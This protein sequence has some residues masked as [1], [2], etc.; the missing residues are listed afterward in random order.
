LKILVI[1]AR[2]QLGRELAAALASAG[3]IV[4]LDRTALN[5]A[6]ADRVGE[7]VRR[8]APMLIVNAAA[9]TA[10]DRA[11]HER[12]A[13]FAVNAIAPAILAGEAKRL[14][15]LLIHYSTDYVFDGRQTTPYGEDATPNPLNAYGESKLGGERAIIASGAAAIIL[16]TS[17]VY[18]LRGSNF[19][20]TM[21]RLAAERDELRV[22]AD[23]VGVPNWARVLAQATAA[24]V[25]CGIP[26]L[27]ERTGVYHLSSS[28]QTTWCEFARAIL[29]GATK[30]RIVP[31]TT[32]DYPTPARRPAYGVLDTRKFERVFGFALP[33][34]RA[35]LQ[36]CVTS[37]AEP[38]PS[39]TAA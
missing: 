24:L 1:G 8:V 6:D 30:P 33:H 36:S 32:A 3:A 12:G 21:R 25:K 39:S 13:A 10:V 35:A 37:P 17:W 11:E 20:L 38:P 7:I 4:A 23:Q 5:L 22:V 14:N 28:G 15:A 16:R 34:W 27:E 31:I 19:L 18:S 9:Y 2:G 26:Y 29:D